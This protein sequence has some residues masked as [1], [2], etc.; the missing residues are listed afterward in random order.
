MTIEE[1]LRFT[2]HNLLQILIAAVVGVLGGAAFSLTQPTLYQT[3]STAYVVA[4]SSDSVG[5]ASAAMSL[6]AMKA[7]AYRSVVNSKRVRDSIATEL[8]PTYPQG[9]R[10]AGLFADTIEGTNQFRI[11]AIASSATEARDVANVAMRATAAEALRLESITA[12]GSSTNRSVVRIVPNDEADAP[13]SPISPTWTRNLLFGLGGGIVAGF[14]VAFI[15]RTIDARLRTQDDVDKLT[16][17]S[18]LGIITKSDELSGGK[19]TSAVIDSGPTAEALRTLRTNLRFVSVDHPPRSM[20][21][22]S[23]NPGE[24]KSTVTAN[25]ARVLAQAGQ[26]VVLIDADLR[27]PTQ[28]KRFGLDTTV[29]LTQVLSGDAHVDDAIQPTGVPGLSVLGAGRVPPNPSELVG[30]Q[31][32]RQLIEALAAEHMVLIDAPPILPVTDAGLLTAASDGAVLI[33]KVGKT[34]KEEVRQSMRLLSRVNAR[35]LGSVMNMTPKGAVGAATYGY[36]YRNYASA[37]TYY[38][39]DSQASADP[40]ATV[41]TP[42]PK[43]ARRGDAI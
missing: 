30:S 34:R 40:G 37:K 28:A 15:R 19:G 42:K 3:T 31:R 38:A 35:L 18:V 23:A 21:I 29:G 24:G 36:G 12:D 13:A 4:G 16:G 32:M 27:R 8:A 2:R 5:A 17:A 6:G 33:I 9:V 26:K 14:V 7:S 39:T 10:I 1:F 22:T 11:T 25:L 20:V 43:R 41:P